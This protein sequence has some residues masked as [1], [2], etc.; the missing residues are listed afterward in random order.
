ME[1]DFLALFTIDNLRLRNI[2]VRGR[3]PEEQAVEFAEALEDTLGPLAETSEVD[4]TVQRAVDQIKLDA[5]EREAR[6]MQT[7]YLAT[8]VILAG[9]AIASGVI[10][11]FA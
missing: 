4:R 2:L 3:M 7:I 11:A 1:T 10:I 9:L 6:L 5:A 8:A